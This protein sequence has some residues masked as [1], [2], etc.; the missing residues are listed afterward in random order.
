[1]EKCS[2]GFVCLWRALIAVAISEM[3]AVR[4]RG[5]RAAGQPGLPRIPQ[6]VHV[7]CLIM[8]GSARIM[9]VGVEHPGYMPDPWHAVVVT[10]RGTAGWRAPGRGPCILLRPALGWMQSRYHGVV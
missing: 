3:G 4:G 6:C 9:W 1:M 5:V 10:V 7:R 8:V 2:G